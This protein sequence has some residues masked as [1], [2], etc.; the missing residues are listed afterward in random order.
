MKIGRLALRREALRR[1]GR[2]NIRFP[3]VTSGA[4]RVALLLKF[5]QK[6]AFEHRRGALVFGI[7]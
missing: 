7:F 6:P 4:C 2:Q 5:G 1:A 3:A